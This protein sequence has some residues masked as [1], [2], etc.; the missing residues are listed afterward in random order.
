MTKQAVYPLSLSK[1]NEPVKVVAIRGGNDLMR[2]LLAMGITNGT[3]LTVLEH[4]QGEGIMVRCQD[5]RW[6]MGPGMAHKILVMQSEESGE[7]SNEY[8]FA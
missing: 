5:T 7:S 4:T 8:L 6:A 2:R 3:Q 1:I